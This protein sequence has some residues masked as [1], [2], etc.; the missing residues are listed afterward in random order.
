MSKISFVLGGIVGY[1]LGAR[2]GH[3]RYEQIVDAGKQV[4]ENP[5]VQEGRH[6]VEETV[7]EQAPGLKQ[8][9]SEAVGKAKDATPDSD[10][11][12]ND[13]SSD[14]AQMAKDAGPAGDFGENTESHQ[15]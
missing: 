13:A 14:E 2:A 3:D 5:R 10:D 1:I 11:G 9:V 12:A 15:Q 7:R 6:K 8:K 4:W